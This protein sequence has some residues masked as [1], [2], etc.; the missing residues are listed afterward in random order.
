M[1]ILPVSAL[2]GVTG[3]GTV[4]GVGTAAAASTGGSGFA[5][6]LAG[7]VDNVQQLQSTANDLAVKAV[8]G[9]LDD[10]ATATVA[11]TRAQVTT[12]LVAAVRN[13]GISAFTKI[14]EMPA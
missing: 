10:I 11:A 8:T 6:S 7:A 3:S 13:D 1:S 4:A 2:S 12:E 9:N 5:A 14:M